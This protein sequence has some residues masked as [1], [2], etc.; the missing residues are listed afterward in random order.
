[1]KDLS[2]HIVSFDIP[3]PANY[4]GV[5]DVFYKLV[6]LKKAGLKIH[7]HCFEY[8]REHAA[9]LND[10]CKTVHYY[11][12]KTGISSNL[13]LM[14]YIVKSRNS[15]LLMENLLKDNHPILFEGI[16]TCLF[17]DDERLKN[18]L[19]IYRESNIEHHYY[20]HLF[21]ADKN[22]GRKL[23]FILEAFKLRLFQRKLK[24]ANMM[25]AV[26]QTDT[27][28]LQ[29]HFPLKK[30]IYLPSFHS[31]DDFSV[32]PGKGDY[33][34]YHGKLSVTENF[35]AVEYLITHVFAGSPHKLV[36]AGLDP[37]D[38]LIKLIKSHSNVQLIANPDD[39]TMFSLI[40]NAQVNILITFQA[41]GLKLKLLNT[42]Y[43][44]RFCL[45]NPAMVHGAGLESL[46]ESGKSP[47]ELRDKLNQL[48]DK[49]FDIAE[50]EKRKEILL[51]HYSN[52]RNAEQLIR[53]VF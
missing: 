46:C 50:V 34:F 41:T 31:N 18:R 17:I 51:K 7:L 10:L 11:P 42:L 4:G 23:F 48:F 2:L 36:I 53:L 3:Y 49:E 29:K 39:E 12:R 44:G 21:K 22:P 33:A 19:K 6:A 38:H 16:H 30:V 32:L 52:V 28:Y 14:P 47:N 24:H 37:P 26:S 9:I 25:L 45:V 1:M 35:K 27:E 40:R 20:F 43:K 5:I 15:K 13:S 8:G